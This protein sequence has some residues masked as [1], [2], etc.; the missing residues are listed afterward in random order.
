VGFFVPLRKKCNY[1]VVNSSQRDG[2]GVPAVWSRYISSD[3]IFLKGFKALT[4]YKQCIKNIYKQF[5]FFLQTVV[6]LF[7]VYI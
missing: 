6:S 4:R 1:F 3:R 2:A 7:R 5:I